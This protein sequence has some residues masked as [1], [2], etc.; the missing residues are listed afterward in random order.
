MIDLHTHTTA[1]DGQYSP[2]SLIEKAKKSGLSLIAITDHNTTQG[3]SEAEIAT[4]EEDITLVKGVELNIEWATGE[5]HLLALGIKNVSPAL[6]EICAHLEKSR[7]ERNKIIVQKLNENGVD[8]SYEELVKSFPFSQIGRPHIASFL[9]EKK[10]VRTRQQAFQKYLGSGRPCFEKMTGANLDEAV[11]AIVDSN[12]APVIAHPLSLY[13][14]WGKMEEVLK[15]IFERG[16]AGLEA[17]HPGARNGACNRLEKLARSIGF[18]ITAGSDFHGEKV[19]SDR[20]LG[21]TS[22]NKKIEDTF[23]TDELLPY[24][25]SL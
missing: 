21:H 19:R 11:Q 16:V 13:V 1:S 24:L 7:I 15:N 3:F 6:K 18:F 22:G 17:F 2:K 9:V 12:A 5:F 23:Y 14:S 8:I 10:V 4:K 20:K 25:S